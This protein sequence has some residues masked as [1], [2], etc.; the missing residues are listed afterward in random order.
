MRFEYADKGISFSTICPGNII[1]PIFKKSFDG[2]VHD[3]FDIP[4]DA[5]P[6]DLAAEFTLDQVEQKKGIIIVPEELK[7]LWQGYVI[8][9]M[10]DFFLNMARER[11]ESIENKGT[12]I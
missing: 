2:A 5:I 9:L 11:R 7:K 8:G 10:D 12:Y 4:E 6:A 3:E 1:T